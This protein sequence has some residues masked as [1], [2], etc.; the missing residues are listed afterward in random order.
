M[1]NRWGNNGNSE[2]LSFWAPKSLQIVTAA[3]KLKDAPWKKSYDQPRQHIKK[4]RRYFANKGPSSQGYG[5]SSGHVWMWD[6]DYKES[7]A[8]KN[9]CF[10]T[11]VLEK[12]LANPLDCKAI[13]PVHPKGDQSWVFIGRTY[14]EAET[15]ILWAPDAKSWVI[16]KDPDAGIDWGQ[17]EKGTTEDEMV[18][19]HHLLDEHGFGWTL[20]VCDGQGA[21]CAAVHGVSEESDWI[22]R[23]KT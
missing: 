5:F 1:A 14:F 22:C 21:W 3:M 23:C 11:V 7:W 17:E 19:W 12:T 9:W 6:L 2:R 13:Q 18:G 15:P 4:Q 20:G 8:L 10:W 16:W